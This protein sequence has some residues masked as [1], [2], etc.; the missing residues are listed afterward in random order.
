MEQK[1][2]KLI[3]QLE[4]CE[5]K[6]IP[7]IEKAIDEV[8]D[9]SARLHARTVAVKQALRVCTEECVQRLEERCEEMLEEIDSL[10]L[11]KHDVLQV[12][13]ERLQ[14][15]LDK[16]VT[17]RDFV[18]HSFKHGSEAEIFQLYD[19]MTN[20]LTEL[21][22]VTLAYKE[23][24]DNDVIE[25]IYRTQDVCIIDQNLGKVSTSRIFIAHCFAEGPGLK[26]GKVGIESHFKL[27]VY[28]RFGDAC[29]EKDHDDAIRVKIQAPEGFYIN[30]K[31][32][33]N[34]DGSYTAKYTPVTKGKHE[35]RIKIRG[36][37][38]PNNT[39]VV[40]VYEGID[41]AKVR[42]Q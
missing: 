12:Q 17:A 29:V 25:H 4:I 40:K 6:Q 41:Y 3:N 36:R 23:P 34:G 18:D 5:R 11:G 20:R 1:K 10:Y 21:N 8:Q 19:V 33:N 16:N 35:L 14:R 13:K 32:T 42:V 15:E 39:R 2:P 28:D 38:I 37:P 27:Y 22:G 31:L 7:P 30:N 24:E 9:M 26:T